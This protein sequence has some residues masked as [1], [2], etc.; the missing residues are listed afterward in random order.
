MGQIGRREQD[1][2]RFGQPCS[3]GQPAQVFTLGLIEV[4]DGECLREIIPGRLVLRLII[5]IDIS[6]RQ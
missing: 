1:G 2:D 6:S 3:G 4:Q 5:A